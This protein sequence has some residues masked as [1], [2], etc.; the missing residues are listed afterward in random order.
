MAC[1]VLFRSR[2]DAL[3]VAVKVH[4]FVELGGLLALTRQK[5]T[6][7]GLQQGQEDGILASPFGLVS[8]L[9]SGA[10]PGAAVELE[11]MDVF[12]AVFW[13]LGG[14]KKPLAANSCSATRRFQNL[15]QRKAENY[16]KS[17]FPICYD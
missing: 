8:D 2:A 9:S 17:T 1:E 14:K 16:L 13:T 10:E 11:K 6:F 12:P 4:F 15:L 5:T 3:L 7:L